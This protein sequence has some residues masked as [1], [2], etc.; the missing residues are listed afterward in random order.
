[1]RKDEE[2]K[3]AVASA[4]TDPLSRSLSATLSWVMAP[5]SLTTHHQHAEINKWRKINK[6]VQY[7]LSRG[8]CQ[9]SRDN[10]KIRL[11]YFL[12]YLH[13][14]YRCPTER[15]DRAYWCF[16]ESISYVPDT[17][18]YTTLPSARTKPLKA[19]LSP[20][21][22]HCEDWVLRCHL[23]ANLSCSCWDSNVTSKCWLLII[24]LKEKLQIPSCAPGYFWSAPAL[25][26]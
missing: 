15:R 3:L 14:S 22:S 18:A 26:E 16:C 11:W 5:F 2:R 8:K 7:S 13:A 25:R 20:H 10:W 19:T 4:H 12:G 23:S 9:K 1:M 6:N 24:K 21:E 17:F